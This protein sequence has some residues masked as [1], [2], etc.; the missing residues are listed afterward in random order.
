MAKN[1]YPYCSDEILNECMDII[2][3]L[4]AQ[5]LKKLFKTSGQVGECFH[6]YAMTELK[7][8]SLGPG[9]KVIE[10]FLI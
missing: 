4:D 1:E 9:G 5:N 10:G 8:R 3:K 7:Q 2:Y 6:D